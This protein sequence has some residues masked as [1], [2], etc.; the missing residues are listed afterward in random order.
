VAGGRPYVDAEKSLGLAALDIEVPLRVL[1]E[2]LE[3]GA[4]GAGRE[5]SPA[6]SANV[7]LFRVP[8][9]GGSMLAG[10]ALLAEAESSVSLSGEGMRLGWR[11][12]ETNYA[13]SYWAPV[14][15]GAEHTIFSFIS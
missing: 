2:Y 10:L 13:V 11:S 4:F 14:Y 1:L 5:T 8:G 3:P 15:L 12:C 9:G 6:R 7:F